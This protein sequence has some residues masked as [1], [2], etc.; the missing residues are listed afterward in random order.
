MVPPSEVDPKELEKKLNLIV[1]L[2]RFKNFPDSQSKQ[3]DVTHLALQGSLARLDEKNIYKA[4][5]GFIKQLCINLED[6]EIDNQV[7]KLSYQREQLKDPDNCKGVPA[8]CKALKVDNL[9][10]YDLLKTNVEE[11]EEKE[12]NYPLITLL[13]C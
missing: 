2:L 5:E 11:K 12:I 8:L 13:K 3:R 6:D 9:S 10:S 4:L 1:S 7:N